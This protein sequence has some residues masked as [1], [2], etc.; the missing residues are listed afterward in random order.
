[1]ITSYTIFWCKF[2]R[3]RPY[4]CNGKLDWLDVDPYPKNQTMIHKIQLP[5]SENYQLAVAA[6]TE[7]FSSGKN[8]HI[9]L[10]NE[11]FDFNRNGLVNMHNH[12]N[13]SV[14]QSKKC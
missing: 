1:M 10:D 7:H 11:E 4:Q 9:S 12:Q 6:N 8:D 5:D 2:P 14:L 3:D 13:E